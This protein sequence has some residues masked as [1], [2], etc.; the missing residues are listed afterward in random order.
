MTALMMKSDAATGLAEAELARH[1]ALGV[2]KFFSLHALWRACNGSA[3]DSPEA[4]AVLAMP[5]IN[6]VSG[7]FA[8]LDRLRVGRP[9]ERCAKGSTSEVLFSMTED[10]QEDGCWRKGDT[11][12]TWYVASAYA[13]YLDGG[14]ASCDKDF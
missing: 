2:D 11:M 5:M 8:N 6:G 14:G 1:Q 13:W 12:A 9:L 4:W 10:D 7:Y 3:E